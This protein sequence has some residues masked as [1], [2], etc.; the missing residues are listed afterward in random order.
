MYKE[1]GRSASIEDKHCVVCVFKLPMVF[2]TLKF[3]M[4]VHL[5]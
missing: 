3:K 1:V 4:I 5:K 2:M